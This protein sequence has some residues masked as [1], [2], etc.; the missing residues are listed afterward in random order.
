MKNIRKNIIFS[1]IGYILPILAALATIPIMTAKLGVDLYGLYVIC[2]SLIGFMTLVDLGIGQTIVKYVAEY[3][4]TG[5]LIKVKPMLRVALFIYLVIGCASVLGLYLGA[6]YLAAGLYQD[7]V[8]Q[9]LAQDVLRITALPLFFSYLNQFYLNICKA[10]HRFDL[11]AIIHNSA[12]IGGIMVAT[13]VLLFGY[14]LREVIWGYVFVQ[15]IALLSGYWASQ[16]ILPV[17]MSIYPHFEKAI[18]K[19]IVSFS[20]YTFVSNFISSLASR[21]DKLLIGLII[22]TEAVTYYQI[23]F[24]IAQMANGIIHTLV[25][26]T[27]P[28]FSEMFSTNDKAGILSLYK[29]ATDIA[30]LVSMMIAV[31]LI[32]VGSDFLSLW[33][34]PSFAHLASTPLVIMAVYFFL[35]SN[36]VVGY[37]VLQGG[38]QAKLTA[39]MSLMDAIAYFAALYYLGKSYG[40]T[41]A[42]I[43]LFFQLITLPLQYVWIARH[44]GPSVLSYVT[45]L[46]S[47]LLIGYSLI[48]VL[49]Y[50]NQWI[51]HNMGEIILDG[52]LVLTLL[53]IAL[54]AIMMRQDVKKSMPKA[55]QFKS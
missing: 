30:F 6:P 1:G 31:M 3:E 16:Q 55:V 44:L 7:S 32:A 41:G 39:F 51:G 9:A 24:T 19:E 36:T 2:A 48:Y 52:V 26:I 22:G 33:I 13:L 42:A 25:H 12:N 4:A 23:P 35:H 17:R 27:F 11:P 43:A 53:G 40:S 8:K 21:A 37:W 49:A 14:S 10:Y 46:L 29:M 34:S 54:R 20:A 28:R 47:F 45:Q 5:Q 50:I 18:F 15:L 38:G